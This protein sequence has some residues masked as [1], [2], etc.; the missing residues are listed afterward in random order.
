[1]LRRAG[2]RDWRQE[3]FS[4]PPRM[5]RVIYP[6]PSIQAHILEPTITYSPGPNPVLYVVDSAPVAWGATGASDAVTTSLTALGYRI[7]VVA[8][9]RR[10]RLEADVLAAWVADLE[11]LRGGVGGG[12]PTRGAF[13]QFFV[14]GAGGR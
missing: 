5:S 1:M 9:R 13:A 6:F 3:T 11:P 12:A 8:P 4:S 2:A 14:R 10:E 7:V